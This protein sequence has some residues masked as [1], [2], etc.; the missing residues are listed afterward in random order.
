V[1][2]YADFAAA[3][4]Q[5]ATAGRLAGTVTSK[6]ERKTR[7]GNKMGIVTFSDSSG[8]YEAVLFSEAL[9]QYR[10]LL[11]PG[12]SLVI[13]VG[14]DER[15]EGIG[16]RIQTVKSLEDRAMSMQSALRVYVRDSGPLAA[17]AAHLN[18]KGEGLVSFVLIKEDGRR[19]I[20]VELPER[21]AISPQVASALRAAA[22]V[23][24]VELV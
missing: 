13:T 22:G 19:E 5:G 9:A 2:T 4:K 3:V 18:A 15:P 10:D 17:I 8:Q 1:Q 21:Y 11:E 20:E 12:S 24:D 7:T 23:I 6:Q 14:A 16:L